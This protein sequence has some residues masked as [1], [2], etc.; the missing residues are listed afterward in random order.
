[1]RICLPLRFLTKSSN[2]ILRSGFT[3]GLYM[4][5]FNNMIA[6]A[7]IKMV[8]GF[9]NCL[10]T[11]GLQMQYLWLQDTPEEKNGDQIQGVIDIPFRTNQQ[12]HFSQ[13]AESVLAASYA[14]NYLLFYYILSANDS[15]LNADDLVL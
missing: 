11:P 3:F 9:L 15:S 8:S 12:N 2:F 10:T 7:R 1:M 6:K 13:D 5:V 4:S 14:K